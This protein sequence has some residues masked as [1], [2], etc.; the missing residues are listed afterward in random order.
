MVNIDRTFPRQV[1][2]VVLIAGGIAAYPLARYGSEEVVLAVVAG[3][4]LSTVNVLLGFLAIECSFERSYSTFLK[5][6]LGGMGLRMVLMLGAMWVLISVFQMY[7]LA[8]ALSML[9]FYLV[10]LV[11]EILYIQRKVVVKNQG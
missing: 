7:A 2:A 8:L 9:G 1:G 10:Y 3:M 4:L 5:A 6:V 11:M